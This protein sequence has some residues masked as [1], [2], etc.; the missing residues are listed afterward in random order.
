MLWLLTGVTTV[1]LLVIAMFVKDISKIQTTVARPAALSDSARTLGHGSASGTTRRVSPRQH[2]SAVLHPQ[3]TDT[4]AGLSY[5]RLAS[6]WR[7]GCP[8]DLNSPMFSWS[9]GENAVAGQVSIGGSVI[10]WHGLACSGR[11]Q[12]QFAYASPADLEPTAM[13]LVGA[14]N[15]AYYAGVPH[16]R[17]IEDS[18]AMQVSG[19]Q[20][21]MVEFGMNYQ[22][23]ASQ[24]L[25]WG[26][27]LGA[28]VV[29]DR[30]VLQAPAVFYV[31]VP[32]NLG[33]QNVT[34]LIDSLRLS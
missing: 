22:D 17:T 14:L 5:Q 11:L 28:V 26:S 27:E 16:S 6:P 30:G 31:S 12:Q 29:V 10:D 21:W 32:A 7:Q 25:T 3:V 34:T 18:S 23:G 24:G 20:A 4:A 15:P 13:G 1:A 9:A 33:T 2:R 19:H 8:S